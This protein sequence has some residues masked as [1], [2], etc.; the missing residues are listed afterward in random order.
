MEVQAL[1]CSSTAKR[2][3]FSTSLLKIRFPRPVSSIASC[4]LCTRGFFIS[5][6][7]IYISNVGDSR[8]VLCRGGKPLRLSFDHKPS[9]REEEDRINAIGGYVMGETGRVNG[10]LAVSRSVGDFFMHPYVSFSLY[11]SQAHRGRIITPFLH[12]PRLIAY[13]YVGVA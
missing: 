2:L 11:L 8:A 3:L 6:E 7:Q 4:F 10:V 9:S 13:L 5:S 1:P 12:A